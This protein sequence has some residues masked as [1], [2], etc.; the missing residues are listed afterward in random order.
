MTFT[1][2]PKGMRILIAAILVLFV[3]MATGYCSKA[4][5]QEN[6]EE[7]GLSLG[8]GIAT[9]GSEPC[10]HSMLLAQTI[11][12]KWLGYLATH[13]DSDD[14]RNQ[15]VTA[16]F[17]VGIIRTATVNRWTL[18]FGAGF[19]EHGDIVIGDYDWR[20]QTPYD[21]GPQLVAAILVRFRLHKH[22]S[23]D[24]LHNSTGGSTTENRGLNSIVI[25]GRF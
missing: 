24:L 10:F 15:S 22:V 23:L 18:G 5:A 16:N 3:A 4:D 21:E 14:C 12:D 13:G 2:N 19:R 20:T 7:Q 8:F 9:A 11:G 1:G 6:P 25:S 17:G